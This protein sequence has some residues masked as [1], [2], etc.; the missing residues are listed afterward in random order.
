MGILVVCLGSSIR[1]YNEIGPVAVTDCVS[2]IGTIIGTSVF[3]DVRRSNGTTQLSLIVSMR[4]GSYFSMLMNINME[5]CGNGDVGVVAVGAAGVGVTAV[6]TPITSAGEFSVCPLTVKPFGNARGRSCTFLP[7]AERMAVLP[8][9]TNEPS[10][11]L[12]SARDARSATGTFS[13][14]AYHRDFGIQM[15]QVAIDHDLASQDP[16]SSRHK[17]SIG[18]YPLPVPVDD[19]I[20]FGALDGLSG[21]RKAICVRKAGKRYAMCCAMLCCVFAFDEVIYNE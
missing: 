5:N 4:D 14:I 3:N 7:F 12:G 11:A 16:S 13:I 9:T 15:L 2:S 8:D 19:M 21:V 10:L 18:E 17:R 1:I 6:A 20:S